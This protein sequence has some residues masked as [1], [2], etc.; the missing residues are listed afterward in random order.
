MKSYEILQHCNESR[1]E[2]N[3]VKISTVPYNQTYTTI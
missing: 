1:A 2:W 3:L